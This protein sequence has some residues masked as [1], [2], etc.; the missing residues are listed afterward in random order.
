LIQQTIA[1]YLTSYA[2]AW[3]LH[4]TVLVA[5]DGEVLFEQS[6]G[7]AN[8]EHNIPNGPDT[9]YKGWSLTKAFTA[10]ACQ[11]L[12]EAQRL[13]LDTTLDYYFPSFSQ[14]E[15]IT[16]DQLLHHQSGLINFTSIPEYNEV[17]N[18]SFMSEHSFIQ[19]ICQYPLQSKPGTTFSYNNTGYYLLSL[20][21]EKIMDMPYEQFVHNYICVPLGLNS[22][23]IDNGLQL[24]PNL[25]AP[26]QA[27]E[28][29]FVPAQYVHMSSIKGAGALYTT[30]RDLLAWN[31]ALYH[32][33][34][35]EL[36]L[37][38]DLL[39]ADSPYELGW[40][41][42]QYFD[43]IR[44]YHS[45]SYR[46]YK[47]E[48]HRLPVLGYVV[49]VLSNVECIPTTHIAKSLLSIIIQ[50][51][52]NETIDVHSL[53]AKKSNVEL[54]VEDV[55]AVTGEYSDYGI[56]TSVYV[57]NEQLTVLWDSRYKWILN[58]SS[59]GQYQ[60]QWFDQT[61]SLINTPDGNIRFQGLTKL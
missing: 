57:E 48:L 35:L 59:S 9:V 16:I 60:H 26:Y 51:E 61:F 11:Q 19:W 21:I 50:S 14:Y 24:I 1:S 28:Q 5:K 41:K 12:I 3:P 6:Y 31:E 34:L 58:K 20:I 44:H 32:G 33:K 40:F 36:S 25:A 2:K 4:G 38:N 56:H 22:S 52:H 30:A 13:T 15:P 27:H 18:S 46:G 8:I 23:G 39:Y 43:T 10:T 29:G 17:L 55:E 47:S 7:L 42:D 49:I 53:I 54:T 37:I 45:G